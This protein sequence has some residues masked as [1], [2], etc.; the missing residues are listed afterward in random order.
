MKEQIALVTGASAGI[1]RA[2]ALALSSAGFLTY[3]S[4]RQ[5][6][7]LLDLQEHGVKPLELDVT[8][9]ATMEKAVRTIEE[10]HGCI[11]LLVNNA[12]YSEMGP[13]EEISSERIRRQFKTNVFGPIHLSQLVI[14]A[15]RRQGAGRIINV[16]S[17]GGTFTTPYSGIYHA[18]K[19]A[20]E[21]ISDALRYE[22]E[23]FG[24]EVVVIQPAVVN[25]R[26]A[27]M[28]SE[29]FP[30]PPDSPYREE[31]LA[32]RRFLQDNA[33]ANKDP[34]LPEDVAKVILKAAI[35]PKPETRYRAGKEAEQ[36][37]Q[38]RRQ[39]SDREWDALFRGQFGV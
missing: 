19:Y 3:G 28:V 11:D 27:G 23:P 16:S 32:Y 10:R 22:L 4:A 12:G 1:G 39:L 25:T 14:P 36:L 26:S 7:A 24:I 9:E 8:R 29:N 35:A 38:M 13:I 31:L 20:L 37:Q 33:S 21:S 6:D 17:M 30:I 2:T 34:V 18:S 5:P 15:M